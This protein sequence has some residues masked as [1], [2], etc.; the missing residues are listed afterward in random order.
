M[1][2]VRLPERVPPDELLLVGNPQRCCDSDVK[3]PSFYCGVY[4][5]TT[6]LVGDGGFFREAVAPR[7]ELTPDE[8]VTTEAILT[9][10]ALLTLADV[11]SRASELDTFWLSLPA[12]FHIKRFLLFTCAAALPGPPPNHVPPPLDVEPGD[13]RLETEVFFGH[14]PLE[15]H[16]WKRHS[17]LRL[18]SRRE[19]GD[20]LENLP[21]STRICDK[22]RADLS[23][24]YRNL[25]TELLQKW[26]EVNW[27]PTVAQA[28]ER[29]RRERR[30]VLVF[31]R[32]SLFGRADGLV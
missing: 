14:A 11:K 23:F 25:P 29:A 20:F 13:S 16:L 30:P 12:P 31:L 6:P 22:D 2:R 5:E 26:R 18:L 28:C 1:G 19:Y 8:I 10:H 7:L 32:A 24:M 27:C 15:R 3:M 17:F 4:S 21:P 9:Q